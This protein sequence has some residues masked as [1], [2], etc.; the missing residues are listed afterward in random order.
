MKLLLVSNIQLNAPNS[1]NL[2]IKSFHKWQDDRLT[3]LQ[4]LFDKT[5]QYG[6]RTVML[7]GTLFGQKV[8]PESIID[9]FFNAVKEDRKLQVFT[10]VGFEEYQLISY[11]KDTPSNF[12]CL[13]MDAVDNFRGKEMKIAV[14]NGMADITVND[15]KVTVKC[16]EEDK[17]VI[18]DS[19]IP[20]FEPV[21]FDDSV[22][23][24]FGFMLWDTDETKNPFKPIA[25]QK[26]RFQTV[27]LKIL[28]AEN[29]KDILEKI[30]RII[31][32]IDRDTF[33]RITITGK[34]AFGLTINPDGLENKLQHHIFSVNVFD[35]SSMDID[36]DMF[37][38][39]ISLR[40]EFVRLALN[41]ESLSEAE[42]NRLISYGW[43]ALS[44]KEMSEE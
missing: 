2:E 16:P 23:K 21:S 38:N 11:R 3:R 40:S 44:G 13:C 1:E 26:Y 6:A 15:Q 31:R 17:Y 22:E 25:E 34:S 19:V 14:M 37:E 4:D 29:E 27:E 41:D 36:A 12:H 28:P 20:S 18:D 30:N 32:K 24:E 7:F 8:V 43:D 10:L 33:L 5:Q 39:D 42:R 35:N 9:G